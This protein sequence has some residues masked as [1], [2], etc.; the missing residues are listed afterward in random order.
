M[1]RALPGPLGGGFKTPTPVASPT[2]S[3][4]KQASEVSA[5]LT[6]F[7]GPNRPKADVKVDSAEMLMNRP[8]MSAKITSQGV[9]MFRVFG[10]G[11]KQAVSTQNA[12][13]LFEHEMY[14]CAHHFTTAAG[15]RAFEVYFWVG[16]EVPEAAAEDALLFAQR[17]A[18]S[19]GGRLVRL[20]QGKETGEFMQAL[21]G[22]I[23]IRRG[24][25]NKY[26]S[27]GPSMLC[28][29]RYMGQIVFDE[30]D[31]A[32]SSLC[33]GFA[34]LVARSGTCY[35]WKGK[36]SDVAEVSCARLVGMDLTVTG[37]LIEH[38]DGSEPASFWA[39]LEGGAKPHSADHW[40]LKP[41][42]DKYCSR[43]FCSDAGSRQQVS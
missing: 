17:E 33:A 7:F 19:L 29:R 36:G 43:L 1:G 12:H 31:F 37:E 22:V 34:Y 30:V 28:G 8:P 24:S 26:D 35:L 32:A 18:R 3:P 13:V 2:R 23:T 40:R 10:D 39:V 6:D 4:T 16:D 42:Y 25:S 21:G 15:K 11:K 20:Q 38:D 5:L 9:K 27:L 14:V 41:N